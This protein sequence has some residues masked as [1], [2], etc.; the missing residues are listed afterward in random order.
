MKITRMDG[1]LNFGEGGGVA[2][3]VVHT[4]PW[5]ARLESGLRYSS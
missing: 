5:E 4:V 2:E 1:I 3:Y